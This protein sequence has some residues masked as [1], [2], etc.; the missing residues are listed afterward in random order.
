MN[1]K[2]YTD[3]SLEKRGLPA[4]DFF[5]QLFP[6]VCRATGTRRQRLG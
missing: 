2:R 4:T 5:V 6:S 3:L 1:M